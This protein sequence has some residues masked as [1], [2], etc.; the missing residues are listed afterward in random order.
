M[1]KKTVPMPAGD[2][3]VAIGMRF[4]KL[5]KSKKMSLI[6]LSKQLRCSVNSIRWM[7]A[8]HRMM[9]FDHIVLAAQILG[10]P[11]EEFTK[12]KE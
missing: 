4:R 12:F 5:R 6:T 2:L 1:I 10:I 3:Q 11:A 7:E 9:R 8:G